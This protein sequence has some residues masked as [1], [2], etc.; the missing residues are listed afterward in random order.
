MNTPP[1]P[2]PRRSLQPTEISQRL[3][4]AV[5]EYDIAKRL[6]ANA[7]SGEETRLAQDAAAFMQGRVHCLRELLTETE[8]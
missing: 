7:R 2:R 1:F 4:D 5:A 6:V 8:K 3:A